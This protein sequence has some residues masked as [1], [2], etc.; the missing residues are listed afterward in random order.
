LIRHLQNKCKQK[1]IT[2]MRILVPQQNT[3][4]KHYLGSL[5]F[6]QSHVINFDK[7]SWD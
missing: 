2:I 5:G 7:P 6:H 3:P 1:D 4:L